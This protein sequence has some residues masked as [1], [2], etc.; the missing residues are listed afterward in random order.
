MV[1]GHSLQAH[2]RQN[3]P[4]VLWKDCWIILGTL[5]ALDFSGNSCIQA[6]SLLSSS[7]FERY[8]RT[9]SLR[10]DLQVYP[11][12]TASAALKKSFAHPPRAVGYVSLF[13]NSCCQPVKLSRITKIKEQHSVPV[14]IKDRPGKNSLSQR[15]RKRSPESKAA[16]QPH[17]A[18][19]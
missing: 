3:C 18:S 6:D 12:G 19:R 11:T 7:E 1:T 9:S 15:G 2:L 4:S 14:H 5:L 16:S 10:K 8:C 17:P 13:P